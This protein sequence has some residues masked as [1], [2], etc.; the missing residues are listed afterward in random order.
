VK[1]LDVTQHQMDMMEAVVCKVAHV[2][3]SKGLGRPNVL[4]LEANVSLRSPNVTL[5]GH[6]VTSFAYFRV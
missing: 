2:T 6:G 3:C 4:I 1:A 5:E